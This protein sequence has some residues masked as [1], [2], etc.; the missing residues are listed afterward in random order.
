MGREGLGEQCHVGVMKFEDFEEEQEQSTRFSLWGRVSSYI[1][2]TFNPH[3]TLFY[4]CPRGSFVY[5]GFT[6][7]P[8]LFPQPRA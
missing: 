2:L 3:L 7:V 1:S 4:H 6:S 8:E 5:K